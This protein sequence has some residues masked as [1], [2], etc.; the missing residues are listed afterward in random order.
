MSHEFWIEPENYQ[1]QNDET[2]IA[3]L[4]NGQNFN[5]VDLGYFDNRFVRFDIIQNGVTQPV[6]GRLGDV[7]AL[8]TALDQDGLVVIIHQTTPAKIT[9]RDWDKFQAFADH[10]GFTGIRAQH[11]ALGFPSDG[12]SETYTRYAKALVAVGHG[13]GSDNN[14]GLEVEFIALSNP[15]TDNPIQGFKVKLLYQGKA[16]ADT[17][18]EVF[19]RAPDQSVTISI[20]R[21]DAAGQAV[22]PVQAGHHYLLDA[23]VLRPA[24]KG[25]GS[26]WETLWA[27]LT[28]AVPK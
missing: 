15:Y 3:N 26:V 7:P 9:Y 18:I 1:V 16:R 19:D 11:Q 13:T 6:Q 21:T 28:F 17:Q 25:Q 14:V 24:P 10:K 23:V 8:V 5:G 12:F 22:I 4:K 20:T 27:A 2:L